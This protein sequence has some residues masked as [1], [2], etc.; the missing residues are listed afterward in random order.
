MKNPPSAPVGESAGIAFRSPARTGPAPPPRPPRPPPPSRRRAH[1]EAVH[2]L[3]VLAAHRAR[4]ARARA[5]ARRATGSAPCS[6]TFTGSTRSVA[7]P[8]FF[9]TSAYS[10][11]DM[12]LDRERAV[13]A[14]LR[15]RARTLPA[16]AHEVHHGA[17][18]AAPEVHGRVHL[19]LDVRERLVARVLHEARDRRPALQDD[20]DAGLRA[21]GGQRQARDRRALEVRVAHEEALVVAGREARRRE[22]PVRPRPERRDLGARAEH[23]AEARDR[24]LAPAR[25]RAARRAR[26]A[27]P[28]RRRPCRTRRRA[29]RERDV[30]LLRLARREREGRLDPRHVARL[31]DREAVRLGRHALERVRAVRGPRARAART[32]SPSGG[33]SRAERRGPSCPRRPCPPGPTGPASAIA[34]VRPSG[35]GSFTSGREA[36]PESPAST[37]REPRPS[38][39]CGI[40][41]RPSASVTTQRVVALTPSKRTSAPAT[42]RLPASRT[43]PATGEP[44]HERRSGARGRRTRRPGRERRGEA[45]LAH[46]DPVARWRSPPRSGT[47][48][49]VP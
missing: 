2:A 47:R 19:D 10:P 1:E 41:K 7:K 31:V 37:T 3:A 26:R 28:P 21:A 35:S 27:R 13:R 15:L 48:R 12:P 22:R 9:R 24:V 38:G 8:G 30:E 4:D 36:Q 39:A 34:S 49:P 5:R 40:E 11:T 18:P 32:R 33:A 14:G 20:R 17:A 29:E 46:G 23:P 43:V 44:G 16:E 6:V 42:G 25:E 45:V